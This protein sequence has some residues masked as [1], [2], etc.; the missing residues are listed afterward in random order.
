M[1]TERQTARALIVNPKQEV[2]LI[3]VSLPWMTS[4]TWTMPGGGIEPGE[5]AE[6]CARREIYEET[7]FSHQGDM[8]PCWHGTIE[9]EHQGKMFRVHEQYFVA[10]VAESFTPTMAKMLDYEKDFS[11][12]I[13]WCASDLLLSPDVY[14]SPKP[15]PNMLQRVLTD[16]LPQQSER[17]SDLMPSNYR[18]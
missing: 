8:Q 17:L 16:Q 18:S 9:F 15:I 12:E 14:C 7:G 11:L 2:L 1:E 13:S 5:T 4:P 3:S 10:R 6:E